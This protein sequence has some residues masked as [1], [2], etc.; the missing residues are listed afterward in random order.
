MSTDQISTAIYHDEDGHP[1]AYSWIEDRIGHE[2]HGWAS[3]QNN[4]HWESQCG[5]GKIL[6][7]HVQSRPVIDDEESAREEVA[8][9]LKTRWHAEV[10]RRAWDVL[11]RTTHRIAQGVEQ[12]VPPEDPEGWV[13]HISMGDIGV[14]LEHPQPFD[15][16]VEL[17][18]RDLCLTEDEREAIESYVDGVDYH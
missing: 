14:E 5:C 12:G 16:I 15:P 13:H 10:R 17:S 6:G 18:H 9:A 8:A 1:I 3:M 2:T 11:W 7:K 4:P